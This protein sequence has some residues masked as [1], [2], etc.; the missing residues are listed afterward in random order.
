MGATD[1]ISLASAHSSPA[2]RSRWRR[3]SS[4]SLLAR[5][6]QQ[7]RNTD[8]VGTELYCALPCRGWKKA[9]FKLPVLSSSVPTERLI[10]LGPH[11]AADGTF[12][13]IQTSQQDAEESAAPF[14]L[15]TYHKEFLQLLLSSWDHAPG[16]I[17]SA[18]ILD[19]DD[20]YKLTRCRVTHRDQ[21]AP[22]VGGRRVAER[23]P[24]VTS[25]LLPRISQEASFPSK[26][27]LSLR[28]S[29]V[30]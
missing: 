7:R 6:I 22:A 15:P 12:G 26:A 27:V 25:Y 14:A 8:H 5:Y 17:R 29:L 28:V 19:G 2:W 23:H 4:A 3:A 10:A 18:D 24:C 13:M 1:Q 16:I 9:S 21:H 11:I 30:S 20:G